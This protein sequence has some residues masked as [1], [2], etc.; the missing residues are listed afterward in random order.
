MKQY[1]IDITKEQKVVIKEYE[2]ELLEQIWIH[3]TMQ[4]KSIHL[5]I[6]ERAGRK[7]NSN[8]IS[9]RLHRFV[10][11]R[12]LI[13][14]TENVSLTRAKVPKYYYKLGIKGYRILTKLEKLEQGKESFNIYKKS[15]SSSIPNIHSDAMS[16]LANKIYLECTK[17]LEPNSFQ[18]LRGVEGSI[19]KKNGKIKWI[20]E[21]GLVIPDWLFLKDGHLIFI[22]M[23]TGSQNQKTILKKIIFYSKLKRILLDEGYTISLVFAVLD[24]SIDVVQKNKAEN[25]TKRVASLKYHI[26]SSELDTEDIFA[27]SAKRVPYLIRKLLDNKEENQK[28][29]VSNWMN[30]VEVIFSEHS[31]YGVRKK[32]IVMELEENVSILEISLK[33]QYQLLVAIK[34]KEG[35]INTFKRVI[36]TMQYASKWNLSNQHSEMIIFVCYEDLNASL[37]DIF[38]FKV[39]VKI[40]KTDYPSLIDSFNKEKKMPKMIKLIGPY[41]QKWT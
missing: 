2:L 29:F 16:I 18:H 34:A 5:F 7:L 17:G 32:D 24:E 21:F 30:L 9:N 6:Q 27:V 11:A 40:Y 14:M 10:E 3:R 36:N 35:E 37:N 38:G 13:K 1:P 8:S 4:A 20:K 26:A 33:N 25:R 28:N 19:I 31:I 41:I 23:D 12:I 22:E 39:S 15:R